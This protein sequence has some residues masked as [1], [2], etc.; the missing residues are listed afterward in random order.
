MSPQ[1]TTDILTCSCII[2]CQFL[3]LKTADF[4]PQRL[5]TSTEVTFWQRWLRHQRDCQEDRHVGFGY[6]VCCGRQWRECRCRCNSTGMPKSRRPLQCDWRPKIHRQRYPPCESS[7]FSQHLR[8]KYFAV[9]YSAP[10]HME[11]DVEGDEGIILLDSTFLGNLV[12]DAETYSASSSQMTATYF[13]AM[14]NLP[15]SNKYVHRLKGQIRLIS[16]SFA[17][18]LVQDSTLWLGKGIRCEI[19][20]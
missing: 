16:Q 8:S 9:I 12:R 14:T 6:G 13:S 15:P 7:R 20:M 3:D 10:S 1:E 2:I 11:G 5:I 18:W 19:T 4:V 17:R